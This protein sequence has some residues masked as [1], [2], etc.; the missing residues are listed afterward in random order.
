MKAKSWRHHYIQQFLIKGFVNSNQ[1]VFIYD[2]EKDEILKDEKSSK[3]V[4]FEK[5]KNTITFDNGNS[6]SILEDELFNKQDGE[7]SKLIKYLQSVDSNSTSIF[8]DGKITGFISFIL[9]L[10]WRIPYS[11]EI[12]KRVIE[13]AI[14]KLENYED[15]K[16]NDS[17]MK[18]Q[19]TMLYRNTLSDLKKLKRKKIG[20]YTRLFEIQHNLFLIGDNPIV[21]NQSPESFDDLFDLD[22]CMAISS[23]RVVMNSLDEVKIFDE[24]KSMDYNYF[25]I[26]QSTKYVCSGD[27]KLLET[28]I[29]YYKKVKPLD[30]D[31]EFKEN[32]F[33]K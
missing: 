13:T 15:L 25:V 28:C 20:F 16:K 22:F 26:S 1:K 5:H 4:L 27:R 23:N 21:Y 30:L 7:F 9:N 18:Q 31:A 32:I 24:N 29:D 33:G 8:N 12:S 3:S 6:T 17:F 11:D 2:K 19:R 10:F 14:S